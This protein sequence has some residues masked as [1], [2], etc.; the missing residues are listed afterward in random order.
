MYNLFRTEGHCPWFF[1]FIVSQQTVGSCWKYLEMVILWCH[2]QSIRNNKQT[3]T[4]LATRID[5]WD[6]KRAFFLQLEQKTKK[7]GWQNFS[8]YEECTLR[9]LLCYKKK[10][11]TFICRTGWVPELAVMGKSAV[12]LWSKTTRDEP[13]FLCAPPLI[14]MHGGEDIYGHWYHYLGTNVSLRSNQGCWI[15]LNV[16]RSS[17]YLVFCAG[18]HEGILS[19]VE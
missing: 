8:V 5:D 3:H 18:D 16:F 1:L 4:N 17:S 10:G 12:S 11:P 2:F 6:P 7:V 19:G 15:T 13:W 9:S 14:R